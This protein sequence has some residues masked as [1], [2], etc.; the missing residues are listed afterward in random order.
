ML[1]HCRK[2]LPSNQRQPDTG[3]MGATGGE[4]PLE[5]QPGLKEKGGLLN[6]AG[7]RILK[8]VRLPPPGASFGHFGIPRWGL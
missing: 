3:T 1:P 6:P 7:R 2:R 5:A 4:A 8:E